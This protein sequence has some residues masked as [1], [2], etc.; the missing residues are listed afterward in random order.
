MKI[1]KFVQPSCAPCRMVDGFLSHLGLTVDETLD[2]A[3]DESAFNLS[4]HFGVKSTPT[5]ILLKD[6]GEEVDRV[7]GLNHE[8]I[9]ELFAKRK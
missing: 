5:M 1:I 7:S 3:F 4:Q 9:K 2:I 8:A 6:N